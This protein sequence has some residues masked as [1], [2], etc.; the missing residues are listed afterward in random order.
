MRLRTILEELDAMDAQYSSLQ[1]RVKKVDADACGPA[2]PPP[3]PPG[4]WERQT[5]PKYGR[6]WVISRQAPK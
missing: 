2:V 5:K 3:K 4:N 1:A 6:R